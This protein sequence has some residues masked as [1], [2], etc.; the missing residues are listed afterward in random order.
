MET[1]DI[2]TLY[3]LT[4]RYW[5]CEIQFD[6]VLDEY[7]G[8]SIDKQGVRDIG[9]LRACD[10]KDEGITDEELENDPNKKIRSEITK[11]FDD[12]RNKVHKV[13]TNKQLKDQ[14]QGS[15]KTQTIADRIFKK[16]KVLT[17]SAAEAETKTEKQIDEEYKK[18]AEKIAELTGKSLYT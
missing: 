13:Y 16:R 14:D 17:R 9:P 6:P 10:I 11:R 7:F 15:K 8:V 1:L 2:I 3:D 5:G 4:D 18:R 12:L